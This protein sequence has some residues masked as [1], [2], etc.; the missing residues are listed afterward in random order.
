MLDG[1]ANEGDTFKF[2]NLKI[3]VGEVDGYRVERVY[4]EKLSE[5]EDGE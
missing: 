4:V 2:E 3:T 1:E 5:E